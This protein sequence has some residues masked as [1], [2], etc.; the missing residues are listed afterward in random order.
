VD[1]VCTGGLTSPK[2]HSYAGD[3]LAG[4]KIGLAERRSDLLLAKVLIHQG[5]RGARGPMLRTK[6]I[7]TYPA[8]DDVGLVS[9]VPVFVRRGAATV[10]S[11]GFLLERR[12]PALE[13]ATP[14]GLSDL[15]IDGATDA[16]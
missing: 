13:S 4:M 9:A 15:A 14:S 11:S 12:P 6:G 16:V 2:F 5:E 3:S 10:C 7:L 8:Q 1:Q